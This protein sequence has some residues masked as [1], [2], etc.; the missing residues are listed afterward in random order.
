MASDLKHIDLKLFFLLLWWLTHLTLFKSRIERM[1]GEISFEVSSS[2]KDSILSDHVKVYGNTSSLTPFLY[3][4]G[5]FI[6]IFMLKN[7][8]ILICH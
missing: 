2:I 3:L 6:D 7:H 8:I 1:E 5:H 4:A